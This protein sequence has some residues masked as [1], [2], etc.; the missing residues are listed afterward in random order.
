M[1]FSEKS[2]LDAYIIG[3]SRKLNFFVYDDVLIDNFAY[4]PKNKWLFHRSVR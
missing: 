2:V 4:P 3:T 1:S